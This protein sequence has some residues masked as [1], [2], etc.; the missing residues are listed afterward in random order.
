MF[1]GSASRLTGRSGMAKRETRISHAS[2]LRGDSARKAGRSSV[3]VE[4]YLA[5]LHPPSSPEQIVSALVAFALPWT[6]RPLRTLLTRLPPRQTQEA[7][8]RQSGYMRQV[9]TGYLEGLTVLE[10]LVYAA[11][12]RFPGT[13]EEQSRR[14]H[15]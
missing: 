3:P 11:M 6:F 8:I 2:P 15:T 14:V 1:K 10:N 4:G 9:N 5:V 13:I 7:Y 12:L